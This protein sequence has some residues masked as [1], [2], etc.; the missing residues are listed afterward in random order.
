MQ[1]ELF[2]REQISQGDLDRMMMEIR[3]SYWH[4]RNLRKV[5]W[6][7]ARRRREYRKVA[8]HKKRLQL[9]GVEKRQILDLLACC[10]LQCGANKQPRKPCKYCRQ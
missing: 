9:A 5:T 10:R 2:E 1:L 3:H 7:N 6:N 8:E 4:L